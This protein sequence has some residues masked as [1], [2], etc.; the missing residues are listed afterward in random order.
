MKKIAEVASKVTWI[1]HH[2]T[3]LP[4]VGSLCRDDR[5]S[6]VFDADHCGAFLAW[7][8]FFPE[9]RL[10]LV[11]SIEDWDLWKKENYWSFQIEE[12]VRNNLNRYQTSSKYP[13]QTDLV[14]GMRKLI[15]SADSDR[16]LVESLQKEGRALIQGRYSYACAQKDESFDLEVGGQVMRAAFSTFAPNEIGEVF[17]THYKKP[18]CVIKQRGNGNIGLSFRSTP[19]LPP[20]HEIARSLGGGGHRCAAGADVPM[21]L[22]R[23]LPDNSWQILQED[24]GQS[25]EELDLTQVRG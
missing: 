14:E 20:V 8:H 2:T 17:T 13:S 10:C 4:I 7:R 1:D 24:K 12:A 9:V 11:N 6:I 19:D 16:S 5:F 25:S 21:S 3:S 22:L 23:Q 18:A 15:E